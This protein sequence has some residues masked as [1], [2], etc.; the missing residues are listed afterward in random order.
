[1]SIFGNAAAA[2]YQVVKDGGG[3]KPQESNLKFTGSGVTVTDSAPDTVV[4]ISPTDTDFYQTIK[5]PAGVAQTQRSV[6][7][8][9]GAPVTVSDIAGETVIDIT[10]SDTDFYQTVKDPSGTAVTQRSVL[11]FTGSGISSVADSGGE[12]VVTVTSGSVSPGDVT[13]ASQ[14]IEADVSANHT[15]TDDTA[16]HSRVSTT[17]T[18][19]SGAVALL[20]T[21]EAFYECDGPS[22]NVLK[23]NLYFDGSKVR[24]CEFGDNVAGGGFVVWAPVMS[25]LVLSPASG[26]RVVEVKEQ[27]SASGSVWTDLANAVGGA[28][29]TCIELKV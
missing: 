23:L 4:D 26:A 6:F 18:V 21:Y 24:V 14:T 19:A 12:T 13:V 2:F 7:K 3:A 8:F 11:K 16:E 29:L 22:T 25:W 10:V 5:N 28:K 9:T 17:F 15:L 27:K 20:I 1:M